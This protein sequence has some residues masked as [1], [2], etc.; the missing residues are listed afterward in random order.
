MVYTQTYH[1]GDLVTNEDGSQGLVFYVNPDGSGGWMVALTDASTDCIW[2]NNVPLGLDFDSTHVLLQLLT[3]ALDGYAN[4]QTL[5]QQENPNDFPAAQTVDFA[6]GWYLPSIGQLLHLN[7]ALGLLDDRFSIYGGQTLNGKYWSST[8]FNTEKIWCLDASLGESQSQGKAIQDNKTLHQR[9][10]AVHDFSCREIVYDTTLLYSWSTGN[11]DPYLVASPAQTTTYSV[12]ATS[13]YGCSNTA[14]QIVIVQQDSSQTIYDTICQGENYVAYGFHI[15]AAEMESAGSYTF[16]RNIYAG[17]CQTEITLQLQVNPVDTVFVDTTICEGDVF[18][19]NDHSYSESGSYFQTFTSSNGCDS[20]VVVRLSVHPDIHISTESQTICPMDREVVLFAQFENVT[21]PNTVEWSFDNRN[22]LHENRVGSDSCAFN[23]IPIQCDVSVPYWVT[24]SDGVCEATST[25]AVYLKDTIAPIIDGTLDTLIVDGCSINDVPNAANTAAKLEQMGVSISDNCT[26]NVYMSVSHSDVSRGSCPIVIERTYRV[27]DICHNYSRTVQTIVVNRP[28]SFLF[29]EIDTARNVQCLEEV[30]G[31]DIHLPTVTDF[32]GTS[33]LPIQFTVDSSAFDG[34]EGDIVYRYSYRDCAEHTRDWTFT[35]HI[36]LEDF[37]IS[38]QD[39]E[40]TVACPSEIVMPAPPVVTSNCGDTLAPTG[41]QIDS[42]AFNG[43]EGDIEYTWTYTDCAEHTHDWTFTY[44]V[45]SEDFAIAEQDVEATVACPSEIVMPT[46]PVVTSNCGDMLAATGPQIDSSAFDGCEGDIE[47]TWIYTDC[48]EHTHDWKF[49]YHVRSE[50]FAIAV[51]DVEETV[52]CPSEIVMP[53]LPV[54]TS[55]CGDVLVPT[56]P[57]IDS[58]AFDGC[59]GDIEYTW[60]YTDCAERTHDW[61]FTYHVQSEDFA[62]SEQDVEETV[63]CPSEIVMPTPPIVTSNCGDTLAPT[64]PQIDSSTFN[65]CEGDIEYTWTYSDCANHTHDWT[66]TYHVQM[67]NHSLVAPEEGETSVPCIEDVV[68]PSAPT[69]QDV[70]GRQVLPAFQ[71]SVTTLNA[72]GSGTVIFTFSYSDCSGQEVFWHYT[73]RIIPNVFTPRE[74]VEVTVHCLSE[75][76]EPETPVVTICG[77]NIELSL[78]EQNG[79]IVGGCGDSVFVYQYAVYD[80][81]YRWVYTYHVVPEDFVVVEPDGMD[82]LGCPSAIEMPT[83]PIVVSPC[84]DVLVPVG[85]QIDSSAFDGCEGQIEYTWTYSDCAD[86]THD[87]TF[88]HY[89]QLEDFVIT[90]PDGMDTLGCPSAVEI[91]TPPI[92]VSSCGDVL[93]PVGPQIDSSAFDGCEGQIEYMWTYSDCTGHTHNWKFTHYIQWEDFVVVEPDGM[94][95]LGCPSAIETPT[96]PV[97][98]SSCGD[99]LVPVGPQIDSSPFNGCEGQ[100]EYT[101]TYSDCVGH[102]HDWTF[103]H[104]IQLEDFAITE[105]DGMDTLG[106][107]SAVE[108][109]TPPVVVSSCGDV[110]VPVGPQID[111][112]SFDGCQGQIEYAW[113]YSDCAGH[114]HNWTFTCWIERNDSPKVLSAGVDSVLFVECFADVQEPNGIP[115]AISSCS[116][117]LLSLLVNTEDDFDGCSGTRAY[118]YQYSDCAGNVSFWHYTY[119]VEDTTAPGFLV[120]IDYDVY[121]NGN[122]DYV[123]DTSITGTPTDLSDNCAPIGHLTVSYVDSVVTDHISSIDTIIRVWRVWDDCYNLT[124]Q[125]QRIYIFPVHHNV[126]TQTLCEENLPL[127]WNGIE[128]YSDKDTTITLQ[129]E[130]QRDSLVTMHFSVLYGSHLSLAQSA[131]TNFAWHDSLYSQSGVFTFEYQNERGCASVDTLK[132][133]VHQVAFSSDTTLICENSLPQ[134]MDGHFIPVGADSVLA[135]VDTLQ[136]SFQCDSIVTRYY[137]I[138]PNPTVHIEDHHI[139][140]SDTL[141]NISAVTNAG[142]IQWSTGSVMQEITVVSPGSYS[143]QAVN[144]YGCEAVDSIILYWQ[145][146]P[147]AAINIPDMCAGSTNVFDIDYDSQASIVL[148][149]NVSSLEVNDTIFLPDG[150][151]CDPYGCSYRSPVTFTDFSPNARIN[152]VN[153]IYYLRLNMEHSYCGDIYINLTCPN[154]Q[155]ADI[156]KFGGDANS[157]CANAISQ[158]SREWTNG[159][160]VLGTTD[161]G[162]PNTN[163]RFLFKC[164]SALN[165]YGTGWNY[166]WSNNTNQNYTYASGAGSLIYRAS[167]AHNGRLDSS[168]VAQRTQFYHPNQSFDALVGC[169]MNGDWYIEVI[170]GYSVDNGYIFGWELALAPELH[171]QNV[172][173]LDTFDVDG[174]W[175]SVT[176]HSTFTITPPA[177]LT[178]DTVVSY[179]VTLYD[180]AGCAFDTTIFVNIWV[181]RD[182][183]I[184]SSICAGDLFNAFGFNF[185]TDLNTRDTLLSRQIQTIHGCDSTIYVQ[186][187]ILPIYHHYD[188]ISVP[189]NQLPYTYR[190]TVIPQ[191]RV[192]PVNI[193]TTYSSADFCDSLLT[194][195]VFIIQNDTVRLDSIVCST[196]LPL[197][198]KGVTFMT[199]SI[200]VVS[201]PQATGADSVFVLSV[202]VVPNPILSVDVAESLC[203]GDTLTVSIGYQDNDNI[204]LMHSESS[205]FETQKIF[206]PDGMSCQP[207]GTYYRS[208]AHF[209]DFIEGGHIL[210]ADD[211]RYLRLKMEHSAVEDL[212]VTLFCPNGQSCK[213]VP[214]E[215]YDGWGSVPHNYF[216]INFGLANR[217]VGQLSCDSTLNPIGEPWNYVWSNNTSQGYQYAG[218]TYGYCYEPNNIHL[219]NN[220]YWDDSNGLGLRS[221]V[222]DSSNVADMSQIY[223]PLQSFNTLVGCPLNG[224]WYIQIQDL[225]EEDNGYLVEWELALSPELLRRT[226]SHIASIHLNGLW[227]ENT[228]GT[229]YRITPPADLAND[230]VVS[231]TVMVTDSAGC[232]YDTSFDVHF[233][234]GNDITVYDTIFRYELPYTFNGRTFPIGSAEDT[235]V[236]FFYT[237]IHGCDSTITYHLHIFT[238]DTV[239]QN[240]IVCESEL[241]YTYDGVVF[242]NAGTLSI[243]HPNTNG[244][245]TTFIYTLIVNSN[246]YSDVSVEITEN[247]L[248]YT[249]LNTTFN[250]DTADAIFILENEAGCDSIVTFTLVVHRNNQME[251]DTTLCDYELPLQWNGRN[252]FMEGTYTETLQDMYGADSILVIHLHV[253][254]TDLE[255]V[256]NTN[257]FCEENS[258]VLEV[259]TSMPDYEWSTGDISKSIVVTSSGTYSVTAT[260]EHCVSEAHFMVESCDFEIFLPNAITPGYHDGLNDYF[261]IHEA[262]YSQISD[263]NFSIIIANRWGEIIFS[264]KDKRFRWNGE[265]K[266][267]IYTNVIYNYVIRYHTLN[268]D[269]KII[270]GSITVL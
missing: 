212:R 224:D 7:S 123:A 51:Q 166:C 46:P 135:F 101:W 244:C 148:H 49:T 84:G 228:S 225:Q 38:E 197:V 151:D 31:D 268:G 241:P 121:R 249:F 28:D 65:G 103:T 83:P 234:V 92:V 146:H 112:S 56:G 180:S 89:I 210:S 127:V 239:R 109:P 250:N 176:N 137:R 132:L 159:N 108:I 21:L 93:V 1:I 29:S 139:D 171:P 44:H 223:H 24:V 36:Q 76:L 187:N 218:G 259:V 242:E 6:H 245:D 19:Y 105:P 37:A 217:I 104:Y 238:C 201:E 246:S 170:D 61:K 253:I 87:W 77:Q 122:N 106:C 134:V 60:T 16:D 264:S 157:S 48:A 200:V 185:Q 53:T 161:F 72:D 209:S 78:L 267:T 138:V 199:D 12:T 15:G 11:S 236:Y 5:Y 147:V 196:E 192:L 111:S 140:C 162:I 247:E 208:Y 202:H 144:D 141:V 211:I 149:S 216:R 243:N 70:C 113:T 154:G 226:N 204:V 30:D 260:E 32:C 97:V 193:D 33:L 64:G 128:F 86:H 160:N 142:W 164:L 143:V 220:P 184:E 229:N 131:C 22:F 3:S 47:Y 125:I 181:P 71:D 248:P 175:I 116:D 227:A 233:F 232:V 45:R 195:T 129:N 98:V 62:I 256:S 43:C 152:S 9:V 8:E 133:T 42:S 240:L 102:T 173:A 2:G 155:K 177:T 179:V 215:D 68:R 263:I 235:T 165:P 136:T 40:E 186:L 207:Y 75:V 231:Y 230:T 35:Y 153:D 96:P 182:T 124:Q 183:L 120:P 82:T 80:S 66:F 17:V 73:Y 39:V 59:E 221:Y 174:P 107:P 126:E 118:T 10:R 4:T 150:T 167:N 26:P 81:V 41:P 178:N 269:E 67:P 257:D 258:A 58:S 74:N 203:A 23:N 188:T 57:Q 54:V 85:P 254:H 219:Q 27:I 34:C 265:V 145:E 110:L 266:G 194:T 156:L 205:H 90:E 79:Q 206:L 14:E 198:W 191:G 255:I 158:A 20:V 94:D 18:V 25:N 130:A 95:T 270:K 190:G 237:N 50:D 252:L 262:Y 63:A 213:I 119:V 251:S 172:F 99:V 117:T 169:P 214:D 88:T 261:S 91:P 52:A 222:M 163:D 13:G 55:N 115:I 189:A 100:I 168:N 69:I 114:T